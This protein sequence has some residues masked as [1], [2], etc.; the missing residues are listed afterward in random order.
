M[1]VQT[2]AFAVLAL[3][4]AMLAYTFSHQ[5][6][7]PV[8]VFTRDASLGATWHDEKVPPDRWVGI[9]LSQAGWERLPGQV[10]HGGVIRGAQPDFSGDVAV[11]GYMGM[12]RSGG[13]SI[14]VREVRYVPAG[15]GKRGRVLITVEVRSPAPD[16]IVTQA[17]TN[18]YDVVTLAKEAWPEGTLA[19]LADGQIAIDVVDQDGRDWGPGQAL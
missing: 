17:L 12:M 16:E 4:L 3:L 1:R 5:E 15:E 8:K 6:G 13:Y 18:P 9:V 11:V 2:P 10:G 14:D 7:A 19:A